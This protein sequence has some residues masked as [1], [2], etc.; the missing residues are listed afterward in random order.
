MSNERLRF[1]AQVR[2]QIVEPNKI[3]LDALVRQSVQ[4]VIHEAQL[5]DDKGGK[6]R[7]D[8][9]FLRAS[10]QMSF[11]GMPTGPNRPA[12]KSKPNSYQWGADNVELKLAN[13]ETGDTIFFGWT[14][15]YAAAREFHDGFL[16]SAVQRWQ[17]IVNNNVRL[18]NA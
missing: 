4:D 2:D 18:L 1:T 5:S 10:G 6:M 12:S 15:S 3:K 8:T 16:S 17:I 9:G 13:V 7:I 14:A 11:T